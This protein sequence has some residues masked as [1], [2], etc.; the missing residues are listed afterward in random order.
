[1]YHASYS[2]ATQMADMHFPRAAFRYLPAGIKAS[3]P[4]LPVFAVCRFNRI[5]LA[6]EVLAAGDADLVGMARAHIADPFIRSKAQAGRLDEIRP[7]IA[8]NQGCIAMVELHQSVTCLMNPTAG[9]EAEWGDGTLTPAPVPRRVLV[10]GGGPAGL[11]AARVAA[12]RGHAV[13]LWE[14][15]AQVGGQVNVAAR[16]TARNEFT[17]ARTWFEAQCRKLGVAIE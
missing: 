7:C 9:R 16:I 5:E 15:E 2:L 10:V 3:I 11:E 14:R 1:A 13:T 6:E 8:C 17:D 12:L 4:H